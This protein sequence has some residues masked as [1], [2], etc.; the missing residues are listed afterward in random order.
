MWGL[1]CKHI[2]IPVYS[3]ALWNVNK[4]K[5]QNYLK[6]K[7]GQKNKTEWRKLIKEKCHWKVKSCNQ[8]ALLAAF[9]PL[10]ICYYSSLLYFAIL[11]LCRVCSTKRCSLDVLLPLN[12]GGTVCE[13]TW[14]QVHTTNLQ[15]IFLIYFWKWSWLAPEISNTKL[16][17]KVNPQVIAS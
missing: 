7:K 9:F 13:I 2:N 17:A 6:N 11:H 16:V 4:T 5:K 14:I 1:T 8:Q 15:E 10:L 3:V 12:A